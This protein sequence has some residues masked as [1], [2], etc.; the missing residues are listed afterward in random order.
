MRR[1]PAGQS[2]AGVAPLPG[3]A[4]TIEGLLARGTAAKRDAAAWREA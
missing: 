2:A 4:K 3:E 1:R